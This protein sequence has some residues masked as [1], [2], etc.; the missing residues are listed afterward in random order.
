MISLQKRKKF[1]MTHSPLRE[2]LKEPAKQ[3]NPI[4]FNRMLHHNKIPCTGT[5]T[6]Q[7]S[8]TFRL[9]Q[10]HYFPFRILNHEMLKA[11]APKTNEG[12]KKRRSYIHAHTRTHTCKHMRAHTHAQTHTYTV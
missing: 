6:I 10:Y 3:G 2:K 1:C 12:E 7:L 4:L 8:K 5:L 11:A 9:A